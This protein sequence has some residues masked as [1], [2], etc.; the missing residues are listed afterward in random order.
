MKKIILLFCLV[1]SHLLFSQKLEFTALAE[2]YNISIR[3]I[4]IWQNKVCYVGTDSKFG[5]IHLKEPKIRKQMK[6]SE[7]KLQF[8][9][10]AH[11]G[12][13]F[14]TINVESPA[15]FYKITKSTFL[16]DKIYVDTIKT[17]FYDAFMFDKNGR[18]LAISDPKKDGKPH[19]RI[20]SS[21]NYKKEEGILPKYKEG[22]AHF[23]ASNSN[24]AMKG[25]QVWIATGGTVSRIFNFNW[26]KPYFWNVYETPFVS[27]SSSTGIYSID[28]YD[29][30]FGI[31][32]GGDYTKQ[33]ENINNI[34]TTNDGGKTWKIQASGKNGGYKTC[35]KIR[36]KSKGKD[37]I[38]V[39]DQ[40]IEFS[41][42]FGKTW[43]KISDEKN[44]YVCEW[45]D[46]NTLVFAGKNR[47]LKAQFKN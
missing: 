14:Y 36:P 47:I 31:A 33:S 5:Y 37:I 19:F 2:N 29:E 45:I 6:L 32:V 25:D 39:G 8:R 16:A 3:A 24:I 22:E 26:H 12:E 38:A 46:E 30:N 4:Q 15:H 41:N 7:E 9:T 18:G 43:T 40:N 20:I 35:V 44:L 21:K 17:A 42:D 27:G 34:A 10:L 11:S 23:A 28:F 13:L 1:V